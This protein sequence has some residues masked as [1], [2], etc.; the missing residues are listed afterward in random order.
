M[1]L[2]QPTRQLERSYTNKAD[3]AEATT[4]KKKTKMKANWRL[5]VNNVKTDTLYES[6][7]RSIFYHGSLRPKVMKSKH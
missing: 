5:E 4:K 6:Y 2:F 1:L 3:T 7:F